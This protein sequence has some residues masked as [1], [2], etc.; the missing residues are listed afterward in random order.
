MSII[1]YDLLFALFKNMAGKYSKRALQTLED[2][3]VLTPDQYYKVRK[4]LL[5]AFGDMLRETERKVLDAKNKI[6]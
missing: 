5:D 2:S 4:V 1:L 6:P 3:N